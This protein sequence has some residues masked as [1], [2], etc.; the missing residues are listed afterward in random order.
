[1]VIGE[2][3]HPDQSYCIPGW[4]IFD[5]TAVVRDPWA[6]SKKLGLY[7]GLISLDQQKSL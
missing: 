1:M 5:N 6:V 4:S 2:A 3:V 7:K